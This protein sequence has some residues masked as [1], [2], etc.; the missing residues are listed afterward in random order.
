MKQFI[1]IIVITALTLAGCA[2]TRKQPPTEAPVSHTPAYTP[3][4]LKTPPSPVSNTGKLSC[5]K[6]N[7]ARILEVVNKGPGCAL[8][9]VK[10]GKTSAVSSSSHGLKHCIDSQKKIRTT[11]EHAGFKCT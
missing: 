4:S 1:V 9:Y 10:S 5:I 2:S 6:G 3:V 8:N 11:L 7:E